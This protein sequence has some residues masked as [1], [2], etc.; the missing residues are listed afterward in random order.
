MVKKKQFE[1]WNQCKH[2][3]TEL[4]KVFNAYYCFYYLTFISKPNEHKILNESVSKI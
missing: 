1:Q 3:N 4:E 2:H